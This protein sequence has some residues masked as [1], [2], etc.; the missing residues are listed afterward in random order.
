MGVVLLLLRGGLGAWLYPMVAAVS[1]GRWRWEAP[2]SGRGAFGSFPYAPA[3][4]LGTFAAVFGFAPW[5][6]W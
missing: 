3:I 2:D 4:A 1:R 6:S 5:A